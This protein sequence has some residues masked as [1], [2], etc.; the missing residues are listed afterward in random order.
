[1]GRNPPFS[2]FLCRIEVMIPTLVMYISLTAINEYYLQKELF[3][4]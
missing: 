4:M 3:K 1:M 2:H